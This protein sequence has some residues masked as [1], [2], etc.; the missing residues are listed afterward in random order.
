MTTRDFDWTNLCKE[1]E[2]E[3]FTEKDVAYTFSTGREFKS[4]GEF[5]GVYTETIDNPIGPA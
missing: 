1:V 4:P 5:G 2:P 3:I